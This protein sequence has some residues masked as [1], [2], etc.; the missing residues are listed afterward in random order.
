MIRGKDYFF[1]NFLV[2]SSGMKKRREKHLCV[3]N[4][5]WYFDYLQEEREDSG[6]EEEEA[7]QEEVGRWE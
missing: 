2:S 5:N 4:L 1:V 7:K 3:C 6:K